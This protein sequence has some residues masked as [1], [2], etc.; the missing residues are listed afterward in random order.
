MTT[1]TYQSGETQAP[2]EN[3]LHRQA[4]KYR[5]LAAAVQDAAAAFTRCGGVPSSGPAG[6]YLPSGSS[7]DSWIKD[8]AEVSP[9]W[10]EPA[11]VAAPAP[12][13]KRPAALRLADANGDAKPRL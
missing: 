8:Q 11:P 1:P 9:H 4:A 12:K 2:I 7:I 6:A 3:L 13:P 10:F 5:L